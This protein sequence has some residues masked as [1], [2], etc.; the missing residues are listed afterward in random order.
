MVSWHPDGAIIVVANERSQFQ[1]YDI[2]LAC[3]K[4]QLI[5]EDVTPSNLLDLASYFKNQ[6]TLVQM[7]WSKKPDVSDYSESYVQ[8]DG[9]LLLRF[10]R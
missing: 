7:E 8:T 3:I 1:C 10:E 4:N 5:S 9:L 6:P 2:A